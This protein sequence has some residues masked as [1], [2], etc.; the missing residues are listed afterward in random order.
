MFLRSVVL[1][2]V[3]LVFLSSNVAFAQSDSSSPSVEEPAAISPD[4]RMIIDRYI[5]ATGGRQAWESL[6]SVQGNGT[7]SIPAASISGTA[8]F[9]ITPD[10]YRN[11]FNMSGGN[12]K[13]ATIVTGRNGDVVWQL[14]GESGHY[15]GKIIEG[16]ARSKSLRQ[17]QF[18][19]MLDLAANF[20]RIELA[21]IEAVDGKPAFRLDMVPRENP[22]VVESRF[23]DQAT[24]LI[25]RNLVKEGGSVQESFYGDYVRVGPVMMHTTTKKMSSGVVLMQVELKN[26]LVN[27]PYLDKYEKMP[28]EIKVL[29]G[30]EIVSPPAIKKEADSK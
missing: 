12:M 24:H 8:E 22:D 1:P 2:T 11:T 29:L 4:A 27:K 16:V 18:N 23:F 25:V 3:A 15:N 13:D 20:S 17:F 6:Q 26:I 9:C 5:E 14:T 21:D 7:V 30:E 19:Q 10:A 28:Y